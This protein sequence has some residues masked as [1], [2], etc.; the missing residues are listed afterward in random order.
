MLRVSL[1]ATNDNAGDLEM[2]ILRLRRHDQ[3]GYFQG[4]W[5]VI[6]VTALASPP[7]RRARRV[8]C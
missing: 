4:G 5:L 6:S 3:L 2:Q 8:R 1:E 7:S